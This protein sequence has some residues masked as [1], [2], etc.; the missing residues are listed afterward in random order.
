MSGRHQKKN[1]VVEHLC[2]TPLCVEVVFCI[3]FFTRDV[4]N[5]CASTTMISIILTTVYLVVALSTTNRDLF[6]GP[7]FL[8][9][10]WLAFL[11]LSVLHHAPAV[12]SSRELQMQKRGPISNKLGRGSGASFRSISAK[13]EAA[14]DI[15]HSCMR[16]SVKLSCLISPLSFLS[17][18]GLFLLPSY[19]QFNKVRARQAY[20]FLLWFLS[21]R[22]FS[23][24]YLQ[25][26]ASGCGNCQR[27]TNIVVARE[28]F[29]L[30]LSL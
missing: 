11:V 26:A 23:W 25:S 13:L 21:S 17:S 24:G 10:L 30:S 19:S 18:L 4:S 14:G 9:N 5:K 2:S 29:T 1:G 3:G 20:F 15:F 27:A 6:L 8:W 7:W 16:S 28:R 22:R 12:L